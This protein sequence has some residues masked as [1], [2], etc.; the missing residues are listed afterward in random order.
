MFFFFLKIRVNYLLVDK[1][2]LQEDWEMVSVLER[3]KITDCWKSLPGHVIIAG[4]LGLD[5]NLA[6]Q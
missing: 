2:P 4:C 6:A 3:W 1:A 5:R